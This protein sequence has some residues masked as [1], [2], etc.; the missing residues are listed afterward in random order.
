MA[1]ATDDSGDGIT[2]TGARTANQPTFRLLGGKYYYAS[3]APSTSIDL[4][5]KMP[6]GS[7]MIVTTQLTAAGKAVLDLPM[8]T[9]R[10]TLV[11]TAD[12]A[13][14]V[15]KIAYNPAY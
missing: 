14:F 9:Y 6:D 2:L 10:L 11:A 8:G 4:E 7:F 1:L 12:V 13:V 15:Q 3:T 5:I